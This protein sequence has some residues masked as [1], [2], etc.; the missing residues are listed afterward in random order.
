MV[1]E[2]LP[3]LSI[4]SNALATGLLLRLC[5]TRHHPKSFATSRLGLVGASFGKKRIS[6]RWPRLC[7]TSATPFIS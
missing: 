6:D 1:C 3:D 4:P 5:T 7:F 2:I